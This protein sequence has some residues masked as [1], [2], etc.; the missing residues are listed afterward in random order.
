MKKVMVLSISIIM[1]ALTWN[2]A[3]AQ[4][5][6]LCF[7][8]CPEQTCYVACP[9]GDLSFGFCISYLGQPLLVHHSQVFMKIV[10]TEGCILEC[11]LECLDKCAYIWYP[12]CVNTPG[13]GSGY[14]W[15]FRIGG[16]CTQAYISLHMISDP[17]PFYQACVA[18][19]TPDF[20][21]DGKVGG[22]DQSDL[23]SAM[24]SSA[25]CYDLNCDGIVD[26][27]D[28]AIFTA[29]WDHNCDQIIGARE[30]TWGAIK[31]MY[32]D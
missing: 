32:T 28:M 24:G 31:S 27:L 9:S 10:C 22:K 20:N 6:P 16:C 15:A 19:K 3:V 17:T 26:A 2:T 5:D 7:A 25:P 11:P 1:L 18:I 8:V 29:H 12:E 21:C 30:L 13:C 14:N 23:N 4:Y